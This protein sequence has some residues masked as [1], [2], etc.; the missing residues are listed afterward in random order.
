[1]RPVPLIAAVLVACHAGADGDPVA[2]DPTDLVTQAPCAAAGDQGLA[3][4]V[5]IGAHPRHGD[6]VP[7]LIRVW[8][9]TRS[10]FDEAIASA[11]AVDRGAAVVRFLDPGDTA[12][13]HTSGTIGL[14]D[15]EAHAAAVRCVADFARSD[16]F[17][18]P[19]SSV[20]LTGV[21][22][23]GTAALFAA[24]DAPI[25]GTVLFEPPLVDQLVLNEPAPDGIVDPTFT[26]GTCTLAGCPFPGRAA[27]LVWTGDGFVH[28]LDGNRVRD[29]DEPF[30]RLLPDPLGGLGFPSSDLY[31]DV[32]A[33]ADTAFDGAIPSG[34]PDPS[35]VQAFWAYRDATEPL[36]TVRDGGGGAWILV[37]THV[38][39]V[40][41]FHEHV[42]I[43]QDAL[44]YADFFRINA[45]AAY[46]ADV[47]G[48]AIDE[49]PA[50]VVIADPDAAGAL[51]EG[52]DD[53]FVLAAELELADRAWSDRWDADLDAVIADDPP[54]P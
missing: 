35:A 54:A 36:S 3:V 13:G 14:D 6:A 44:S 4:R 23:G 17:P 5:Q 10:G 18:R 37:A 22:Q 20:I 31:A 33:H 30:E 12:D 8:P 39:H 41:A 2:W 15:A 49:V 16:A 47:G 52:P 45:D 1:M 9:D 50:G 32:T 34:W 27:R 21:S 28:D 24:I 46:V 7:A 51:P 53:P 25:D 29:A 26:P 42:R 11:P 38:D 40:Q 48:P 19:V 43:A